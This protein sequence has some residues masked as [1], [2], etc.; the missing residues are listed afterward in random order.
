MKYYTTAF[1]FRRKGIEANGLDSGTELYNNKLTALL[2]RHPGDELMVEVEVTEDDLASLG[3]TTHLVRNVEPSRVRIA[4]RFN[5][6][7][8]PC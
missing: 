5:L 2:Y 3:V 1:R 7:G 4:Y 8:K 6:K